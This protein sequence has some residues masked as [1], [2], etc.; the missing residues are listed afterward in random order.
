MEWSV[1]TLCYC[2]QPIYFVTMNTMQKKGLKNPVTIILSTILMLKGR[3]NDN[4][5]DESFIS[6]NNSNF[7]PYRSLGPLKILFWF[8]YKYFYK[9]CNLDL[10]STKHISSTDP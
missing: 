9:K 6:L 4:N 10:K 5:E 3:R 2:K 1:N 8:D 7:S